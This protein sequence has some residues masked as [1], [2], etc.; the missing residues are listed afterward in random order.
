[1]IVIT[2]LTENYDGD[3][4]SVEEL[5]IWSEEYGQT[6]PVVSDGARYIHSSGAK[7]TGEVALPS[8]TLIGPGSVIVVADGEVTES[9]IIGALP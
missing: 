3:P 8:H 5:N 7:G 9:D 2:L 1:M 6:F 4:P